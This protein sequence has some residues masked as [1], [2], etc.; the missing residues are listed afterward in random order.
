MITRSL[1]AA[2]FAPAALTAAACGA[3]NLAAYEREE[4]PACYIDQGAWAGEPRAADY[5]ERSFDDFERQFD[6]FLG[7]LD[8]AVRDGGRESRGA[9]PARFGPL[10]NEAK[11]N[12]GRLGRL[13]PR[14][15]R[16]LDLAPMI[17]QFQEGA[18]WWPRGDHHTEFLAVALAE[19]FAG[20]QN[21]AEHMAVFLTRF[22]RVEALLLDLKYD[23][24]ADGGADPPDLDQ[25]AR[26]ARELR[27]GW[28]AAHP[29]MRR[30][31][32]DRPAMPVGE[33]LS[34]RLQARVTA[35]CQSYSECGDGAECGAGTGG[36]GSVGGDQSE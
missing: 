34:E 20:H 10:H 21:L 35:I 23:E 36:D 24:P 7:G 28:E 15:N 31:I 1:A 12:I 33:S 29:G 14:M 9:W 25:I 11:A 32:F 8:R 5:I 2:L 19:E 26:A 16:P 30:V 4:F 27:A 13:L 6:D 3:G 17:G 18:I 22:E